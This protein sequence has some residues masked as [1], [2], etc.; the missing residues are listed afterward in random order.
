[1]LYLD[2]PTIGLDVVMQK[3]IRN[4]VLEYNRRHGATV[5]LTSHYMDDVKELCERVI[6]I[7]RGRLIYDG[8]LDAIVRR[9]ADHKLLTAD[10]ERPVAREEVEPL[11]ELVEY[12]PSRVVLRVPRGAAPARAAELL[13]RLPVADLAVQDTDVEDVIRAVF[14]A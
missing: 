5:I 2:E 13:A 6:I 1:V 10:F 3:R 14:A 4:F 11:G 7:N 12:E 8:R 9:Y